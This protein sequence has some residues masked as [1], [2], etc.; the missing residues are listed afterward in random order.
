MEH[1]PHL[2]QHMH[3]LQHTPAAAQNQALFADDKNCQTRQ[4]L[5]AS[6]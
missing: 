4:K 5:H 1:A 2:E 6:G 3:Q